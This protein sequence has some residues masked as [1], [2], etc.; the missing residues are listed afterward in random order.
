MKNQ[1]IHFKGK[2]YYKINPTG[3]G[4]E[5]EIW[6]KIKGTCGYMYEDNLLWFAN[7][8]TPEQIKGEL[9]IVE[10]LERWYNEGRLNRKIVEEDI[11]AYP[12]TGTYGRKEYERNSSS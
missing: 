8:K 6:S 9:T 2:W 10:R 12:N 7:D 1:Y 11:H 5:I 3:Y 4:Y